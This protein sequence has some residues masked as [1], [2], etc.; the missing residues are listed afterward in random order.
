MLVKIAVNFDNGRHWPQPVEEALGRA[1]L[2][3][4]RS[5][6]DGSYYWDVRNV[7]R[8]HPALIAALQEWERTRER[9]NFEGPYCADYCEHI[10]EVELPS[11]RYLIQGEYKASDTVLVPEDM[12]WVQV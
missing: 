4:L 1:G 5:Y 7:P 2:A 10:V 8:H 9:S 6:G 12:N 11:G 3:R